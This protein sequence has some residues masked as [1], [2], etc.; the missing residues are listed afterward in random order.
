MRDMTVP[1]GNMT[2][3]CGRRDMTVLWRQESQRAWIDKAAVSYPLLD[4]HTHGRR[5]DLGEAGSL[6]VSQSSA[7][8]LGIRSCT[9]LSAL[10]IRLEGDE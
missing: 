9:C 7:F 5:S 1:C 6:S 8:P 2:V 10:C 3:P 4:K